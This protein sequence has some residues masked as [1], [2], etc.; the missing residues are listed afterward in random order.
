MKRVLSIHDRLIEMYRK[1]KKRL[2]K[3]IDKL[4]KSEEF[5]KKENISSALH[6]T[7]EY[8]QGLYYL[9]NEKNEIIYIGKAGTGNGTS[10]YD[11]MIGHGSGAHNKQVWYAK[12]DKC[13]F[14]RFEKFNDSEIE[15]LERLAI[16]KHQPKYNDKNLSEEVINGLLAKFERN[17]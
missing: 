8:K 6:S 1:L 7:T 3:K 4:V 16:Q 17:S 15:L 14:H 12:V 9:Y 13:K 10:F 5:I 2:Q 11:R